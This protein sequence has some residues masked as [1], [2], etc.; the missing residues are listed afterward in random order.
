MT[1][2]LHLHYSGLE[3]DDHL[4]PLPERAAAND[5]LPRAPVRKVT[6]TPPART[7]IQ[8]VDGIPATLKDRTISD[9]PL[10]SIPPTDQK[11]VAAK[12]VDS[13]SASKTEGNNKHDVYGYES[14]SPDI[15]K[16]N[17]SSTAELYG[18]ESGSPDL[19]LVDN[20]IAADS[21]DSNRTATAIKY[22][23]DGTRVPRRSSLKAGSSYG[24]QPL[25]GRRSPSERRRP[26]PRRNSAIEV[27]VRG[28]RNPVQR[29]RSI[30]FAN[31]VLVKEIRS[32]T[33]MTDNVGDLWLQA[34][35]L[36]QMKEHRRSLLQKYK[37]HGDIADNATPAS[38]PKVA[39]ALAT[40]HHA[41]E[42]N[43][44]DSF[45]GLER[46][47][48][49]SGRRQRNIAWD[50]VLLEQDEQECSGY[51]DEYRI[52][53]L[54]KYTT[55]QSPEKAFARAQQDREAVQEYLTSPRTNKLM[56]RTL[57]RVSC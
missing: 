27:R 53:E 33:E 12:Y 29:R 16:N 55:D 34:D 47:I 44:D 18:Y 13:D 21:T 48:D 50:A 37:H 8:D 24:E 10:P 5:R 41:N 43:H 22:Q 40:I 51:F 28:E 39:P 42:S 14:G 31:K 3:M 2:T 6:P 57:R 17:R 4:S 7:M 49:K 54:Y 20:K 45:R 25:S 19:A 26:P 36:A 1:M 11:G 32:V 56:A 15:S 9:N 38:N 46:Y 23:Y 35:E 30:D 52:A